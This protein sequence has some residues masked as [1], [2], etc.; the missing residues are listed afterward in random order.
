M[1]VFERF[2]QSPRWLILFVCVAALAVSAA[3]FLPHDD[4]GGEDLDC[5]VC[6]AG[7]TSFTDLS[8]VDAGEP[9]VLWTSKGPE[10]RAPLVHERVLETGSPRA[11]PA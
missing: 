4:T 8:V 10:Y 9:P 7:Q 3:A 5:L 6:K 11:P 2:R 1:S